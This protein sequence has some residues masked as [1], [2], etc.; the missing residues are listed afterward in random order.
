MHET[1]LVE[2]TLNAV[3]RKCLEVGIRQ[4]KSITLVIGEFRGALPDLMQ[5]AFHI[6]TRRRP[7][8]FG[9]SLDIIEKDLVLR[10]G[11]CG[12]EFRTEDLHDVRCPACGSSSYVIAQGDELYIESFEGE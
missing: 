5:E 11:A 8:F 6:L 3:E 9:A 2:F 7:V 4:V 12:H 10:C 1:S